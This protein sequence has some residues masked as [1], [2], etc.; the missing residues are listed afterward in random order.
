M[1]EQETVRSALIF[2]VG[3]A[4]M[5][6]ITGRIKRDQRMSMINMLV[7]MAVGA[8]CLELLAQFGTNLA[9]TA[10]GGVLREV[11]MLIVA[12]GFIRILLVFLFQVIFARFAVPAILGDVGMALSLL[13]FALYRMSA[14]GVNLTGILTVSGAAALGIAASLK[15]PLTNLWGGLAVQL[16]NTLH[17]GD[18]I[19]I[20]GVIGQGAI[21]QVVGIRWRYTALAT[22]NNETL[23]I[24]NS[25]LVQSRVN[26]LARRGDVRVPLRRPVEFSVG[27]EWQ[28]SRVIG[29]V[30]A[31]LKRAELPN[32]ARNP[33]PSCICW[34]FDPSAIKYVVRYWITNLLEE[35]WT[36]SAVRL[37]VFAALGREGIEI[38]IPRTEIF[39]NPAADVRE[40]AAN[41]EHTSRVALLSTLELFG[42]LTRDEQ[43]ALAS[44]LQPSP[45]AAGD[46][47]TRQGET[48]ESLY[49]LARGSVAVYYDPEG[50]QATARKQLATLSAP[51]Y[52]GEM[53][54]LTGRPRGATVVAV[55]D[56]LCYRL[57]KP[58]FE[59]VLKARPE[60]AE[61]LSQVLVQRQAANEER[62]ASLSADA[63][64]RTMMSRSSELVRRIRQFFGLSE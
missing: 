25:V 60:I 18:W 43:R 36:D 47:I 13:V 40:H 4:F 29:A 31:A 37:H 23:I 45:F 61:A 15:E 19:R 50:G 6:L 34:S 46:V 32:V 49:I 35:D 7:L 26:V 54:L 63:L 33:G 48:A 55:D 39:Y 9:F 44:E 2:I 56:V 52:F 22:N 58:G 11:S 20:E 42:S 10:T 8:V 14:V 24:P 30:D 17:I 38:P 1:I 41:R 59:A 21:G 12:M 51:A 64:A 53:G 3:A 62:L 57:D 28:P 27:Y 5:A 16:D